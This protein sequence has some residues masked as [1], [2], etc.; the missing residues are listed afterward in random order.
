MTLFVTAIIYLPQRFNDQF[1]EQLFKSL[2]RK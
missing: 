2:K 1:H